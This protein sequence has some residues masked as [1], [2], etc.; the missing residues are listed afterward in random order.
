VLGIARGTA[1]VLLGGPGGRRFELSAGDIVVL[2]AGTGHFNAGSSSDLL[3]VGAYP[4]GM[5]RDLRRGDPSE[6]D[7]VLANVARVP[8]PDQDPVRGP[9]GPLIE[10][11]G[12]A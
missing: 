3:V 12:P 8:R 4:G 5:A 6:H 2:P 1:H 7:E 11:W 10:L 9:G